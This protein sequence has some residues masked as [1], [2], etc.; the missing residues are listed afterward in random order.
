MNLVAGQQYIDVDLSLTCNLKYGGFQCSLKSPDLYGNLDCLIHA[1]ENII[2]ILQ[3]GV[4]TQKF[5]FSQ[6]IEFKHAEA[7]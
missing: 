4:C 6:H 1:L 5:W 7:G 3:F 2:S